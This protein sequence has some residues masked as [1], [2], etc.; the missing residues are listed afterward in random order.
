MR[1]D[2]P[3][4]VAPRADAFALGS[5]QDLQ[6]EA[7]G[8]ESTDK[9]GKSSWIGAMWE[10]NGKPIPPWT[11]N[12]WILDLQSRKVVWEL[13]EAATAQGSHGRREF[14][15]SLH[16]P[17]GSYT[18]Y[19]ASFPDGEYWSDDGKKNAADRKWHEFG[20]QPV[21][22]FRLVVRGAGRE[23][24]AALLDE[25]VAAEEQ[26]DVHLIIVHLDSP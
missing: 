26:L 5:P 11:G 23:L 12:A 20:D 15:G 3:W 17:A 13:S 1:R 21:Q 4:I 25:R 16:L 2:H 6:I 8:A 22:D 14:K 9:G 19:F 10:R 18:A 7:V 24:A